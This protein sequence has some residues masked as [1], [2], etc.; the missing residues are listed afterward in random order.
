MRYLTVIFF[1]CSIFYSG[2]SDASDALVGIV[3]KVQGSSQVVRESQIIRAKIGLKL[4]ENDTLKTGENGS[5]GVIFKD[6]TVLSLGPNSI[7]VIDEFVF[8]PREGKL[9]FVMKMVKG[10]MAYMSGII[11]KLSPDTVRF[12]TPVATLGIRGTK[13]VAKIEGIH[14]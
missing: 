2:I 7:L 11:A 5:I 13:F 1:L 3:K 4:M 10:T 8:S 9:S 12:E 14:R 6:N